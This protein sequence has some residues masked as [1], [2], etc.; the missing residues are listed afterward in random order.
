M[1]GFDINPDRWYFDFFAY[2][3][4]GSDPDDLE[5]L[6]DWE[7]PTWKDVTLEGL[8]A[9]QADFDWYHSNE[10]WNDKTFE[11]AYDVSLL[12]VMC[13]YVALIESSLRSGA[14]T[15]SIPVLA[16]AHDFDIVGRF[17]P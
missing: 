8:E 1:N 17:P 15:K 14:R 5:W 6:C 11:S 3:E 7:S 4:Y 13:K 12:L 2:T 9:V 16:T 10:I